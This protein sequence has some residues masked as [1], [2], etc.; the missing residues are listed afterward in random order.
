MNR[1]NLP[2]TIPTSCPNCGAASHKEEEYKKYTAIICLYCNQ[3][4]ACLS[5][6]QR[7]T[8]INTDGGAFVTGNVNTVNNFVGRDNIVV[9]LGDGV[10]NIASGK[11]V[12]VTIK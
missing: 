5:K 3:A 4:I 10:R 8:Q 9:N 11:N 7:I 12:K 6:N 1:W 2:E